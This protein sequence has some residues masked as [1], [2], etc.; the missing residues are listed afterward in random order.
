MAESMDTVESI[1]TVVPTYQCKYFPKEYKSKS[2]LF[3]HC[4][5]HHQEQ[6][7]A[8]KENDTCISTDAGHI[9]CDKCPAK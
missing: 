5:V 3:K 8:D 1:D 6:W 7:E 9:E 2:G 4:K